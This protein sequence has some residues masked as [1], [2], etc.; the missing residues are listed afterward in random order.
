[1]NSGGSKY[2]DHDNDHKGKDI[3]NYKGETQVVIDIN[4]KTMK[5]NIDNLSHILFHSG[6]SN[7]YIWISLKFPTKSLTYYN[8]RYFLSYQ[9]K[10]ILF[11]FS[12]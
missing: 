7:H 1:M 10:F 6:E 2:G 4:D 5:V 3:E 11:F 12:N 8:Y 9:M